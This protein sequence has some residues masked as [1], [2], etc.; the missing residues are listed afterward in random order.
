M[1]DIYALVFCFM[2]KAIEIVQ[3][4]IL[5]FC[6]RYVSFLVLRCIHTLW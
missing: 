6:I 4:I 3:T 2:Q 1:G 5:L